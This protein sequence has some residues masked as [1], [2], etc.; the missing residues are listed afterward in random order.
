MIGHVVG[1]DEERA[2]LREFIGSTPAGPR[3]LVLEGEAGIGKST[4]WQVAV[5]GARQRELPVLTTHRLAGR[6]VIPWMA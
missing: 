2:A 1:R 4:L 3:C 5:D 6:M